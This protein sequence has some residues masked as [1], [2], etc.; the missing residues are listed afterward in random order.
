MLCI[1]VDSTAFSLAITILTRCPWMKSDCALCRRAFRCVTTALMCALSLVF[2]CWCCGVR[3]WRQCCDRQGT[4]LLL[5]AAHSPPASL[6]CVFSRWTPFDLLVLA[7]PLPS[8]QRLVMVVCAAVVF[9][10]GVYCLLWSLRL[11]FHMDGGNR[12]GCRLRSALLSAPLFVQSGFFFAFNCC[13]C[14]DAG[15]A[16]LAADRVQCHRGAIPHA[17]VPRGPREP[18]SVQEDVERQGYLG[19]KLPAVLSLSQAQ[20]I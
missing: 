10:P 1:L 8:L 16:T 11:L 12:R 4:P 14:C 17:D 18:V 15:F 13:V 2:C 19:E 6:D 9:P 20:H 7:L 3:L 5:V